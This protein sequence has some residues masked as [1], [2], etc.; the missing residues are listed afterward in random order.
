MALRVALA[1]DSY[2]MR[3]GIELLLQ[4]CPGIGLTV[5]CGDR[6]SLLEAVAADPPD[7]VVTDIRMPPD[8]DDAGIRISSELHESHPGI[9]VVVLSQYLEPGFALRLFDTGTSGR[10]YLLKERVGS[11]SELSNAIET[12][13]SGGSV[14][15]PKVVE[16]LIEERRRIRESPLSAMTPRELDVL[17]AIAEGKSN[18]AIASDLVLTKRAVEKHVNRIFQKLGLTYSPDAGQVSNRVKATLIFLD[19]DEPQIPKRPS[20]G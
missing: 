16:V 1:E 5:K 12:V 6:R 7:V 2:I 11:R 15:D 10:A 13:A 19:R 9:G 8:E 4:D 14:I 20:S 18:A 17:A 3:R